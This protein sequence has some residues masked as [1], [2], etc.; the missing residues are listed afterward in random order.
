MPVLRTPTN[1]R[2][3]SRGTRGS[4]A[5]YAASG[6]IPAGAVVVVVM[7]PLCDGGARRS[8]GDRTGRWTGHRHVRSPPDRSAPPSHN[9]SMTTTTT[10]P[11]GI[12][13][14][15]AYRAV[16]SRDPRFDGAVR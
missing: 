10:A 3:S 2:P 11:A 8:G 13:P 1:S 12:D 9:G 14:D 15:A 6:S 16:E 4:T 7:L 5:R